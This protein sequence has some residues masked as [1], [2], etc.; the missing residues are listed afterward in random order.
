MLTGMLCL[1]GYGIKTMNPKRAKKMF[2]QNSCFAGVLLVVAI[3]LVKLS[4]NN[5]SKKDKIK[6]DLPFAI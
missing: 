2:I 3:G 4:R 5:K 6:K 1:V